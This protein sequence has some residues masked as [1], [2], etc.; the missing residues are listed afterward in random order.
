ML[1]QFGR[2]MIS[3]VEPGKLREFDTLESSSRDMKSL[4]AF[5]DMALRVKH[6][7]DINLETLGAMTQVMSGLRV[8]HFSTNPTQ[9]DSLLRSL[10]TK[11]QQHRL[12]IKNFSSMIE[13]ANSLSEQVRLFDSRIVPFLT[14]FSSFETPSRFVIVRRRS[15]SP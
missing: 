10:A 4:A 11:Q 6:V 12:G 8:R 3:G 9:I 14:D 7:I 1:S 13:R 2:V 5:V 15:S